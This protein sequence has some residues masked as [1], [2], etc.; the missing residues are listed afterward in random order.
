M[1]KNTEKFTESLGLEQPDAEEQ[2]L[3]SR[4]VTSYTVAALKAAA[5]VDRIYINH[6][7]FVRTVKAM[8][9]IFQL[10]PEMDMPH[11]MVLTGP[12]GAGKTAAFKY[13]RDTLPSSS[14]FAPGD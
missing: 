8:D 2:E 1:K 11:G 6:T 13:F 14:L 4:R 7:A 3:Y 10:A 12:T 9:R 5:P